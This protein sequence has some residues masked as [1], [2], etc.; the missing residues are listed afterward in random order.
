MLVAMQAIR[1]LVVDDQASFRKAIRNV[2]ERT[3]GFEVVAEVTNGEDSVEAACALHPDLVLMDVHLP[4]IDGLEACRRIVCEDSPASVPMVILISA[5]DPSDAADW[6]D[7]SGAAA[8]VP[9]SEFGPERLIAVWT[10]A[11]RLT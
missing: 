11:K 1:V 10:S 2:V 4:G 3:V 9:K 8:Y 6:L 7:G 5:D